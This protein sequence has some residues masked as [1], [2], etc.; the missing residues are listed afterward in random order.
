MRWQLSLAAAVLTRQCLAVSQMHHAMDVPD[1]IRSST[2]MLRT[3][4]SAP[5]LSLP[6]TKHS[7]KLSRC[8]HLLQESSCE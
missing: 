4:S 7:L 2:P 8:C 1:G 3:M 5:L 6:H